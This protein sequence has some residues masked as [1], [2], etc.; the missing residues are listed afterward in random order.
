MPVQARVVSAVTATEAGA[1]FTLYTVEVTPSD[2]G[3]PWTVQHR[4]KCAPSGSGSHVHIPAA[5]LAK[6]LEGVMLAHFIAGLRTPFPPQVLR[7]HSRVSCWLISLLAREPLKHGVLSVTRS[8]QQRQL[9]AAGTV[10][11]LRL[12]RPMCF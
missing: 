1:E 2:G 5:G 3:E 6:P 12:C 8:G 9:A 7:S 11:V 4:F 10:D